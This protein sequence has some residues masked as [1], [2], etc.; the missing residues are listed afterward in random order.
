MTK[1][2]MQIRLDMALQQMRRV[3]EARG[4]PFDRMDLLKTIHQVEDFEEACIETDGKPN[5]SR[6]AISESVRRAMTV[7][8]RMIRD[9]ARKAVDSRLQIDQEEFDRL[10]SLFNRPDEEMYDAVVRETEYQDRRSKEAI[11]R[12]FKQGAAS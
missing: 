6:E 1:Q 10:V 4:L 3:L 8:A 2:E 12:R 7:V 9:A 5:E 11:E